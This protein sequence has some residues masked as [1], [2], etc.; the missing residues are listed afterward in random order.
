MKIVASQAHH[1]HA[2]SW[3]L[4]PGRFLPA[5]E[6]PE[7][8]EIVLKSLEGSQLG[9]VITPVSF[10]EDTALA[11]HDADYLDFLKTAHAGFQE[12]GLEGDPTACVWP[13]GRMRADSSDSI[14]AKF[15]RYC[16]DGVAITQTTYEA[17]VASRDI[18]LTAAQLVEQGDRAAFALCRPPGHHAGPNYAGGYCFLNNAAIAAQWLRNAGA[19]RVGILDIDYHHG[20]GTQEI[21]F[22]RSDVVFASLH[23]DPQFEY[24]FYAGHADEVGEGEGHGFNLN[25]P[26]PAGTTY[27]TWREALSQAIAFVIRCEL[28]CLVVSAGM[29]T[30]LEDPISSFC[31]Q[32]EDYLKVGAQIEAMGMPTVFVFEGG[33][34][35]SALGENVAALLRGFTTGA[36]SRL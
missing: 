1:L 32:T 8:A 28:D 35:V 9:S 33:Y 5:F 30:F 13:R 14:V 4:G 27:A 22:D 18:A 12:L 19:K 10:G 15:G 6:K 24:P 31:L 26:L 3:E 7:R 23:G 36:D 11:V 16:F 17:I 34:A 20:N 2:P 21:F 29:D 25:L